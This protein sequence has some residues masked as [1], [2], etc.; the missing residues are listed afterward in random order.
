METNRARTGSPRITV[1]DFPLPQIASGDLDINVIGQLP[2][3]KFSLRDQFEPC[4]LKVIGFEAAFRRRGLW[5]QSLEDA[6]G[7]SHYA[8]I[9]THADAELDGVSVGVPSGVRWETEEHGPSGV[10]C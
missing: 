6:P 10:F 7:N 9:L 5:K 1:L 8:L 2:P 3:P 4:P